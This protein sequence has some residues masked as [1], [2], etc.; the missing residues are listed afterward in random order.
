MKICYLSDIN[1][2]HTQKWCKYFL[3]QGY[4][5]SVISL[6]KGEYPGVKVYDLEL[7]KDVSRKKSILGKFEYIKRVGLVRK[8][9]NEIKPDILH[10]HYASSYGLL[11][12]LA[13]YHPY[14]I[15]IWGSDIL[16]FPKEGLIQRGIIKYNLKNADRIFST[17]KYMKDEANIYTNKHIDI[18]PF[19]IDFNIFN[20]KK[21]RRNDKIIIG[22]VKSL[23]M[24]YGIDY[25]IK[26]FAKLVN[27]YNTYN[28]E[29]RIL[30]EGTELNF[31]KKLVFKLNV[32]NRV[33]FIRT[34]DEYGVSEFYNDIHI[35]AFPSLSEG[36]GVA[37]LEAQ[38]CGIPVVV[39]NIKAFEETTIP[40]ITSL[41]CEKANEQSL[42][43][44]LEKLVLNSKLREEMGKNAV[45]FV[46]D[47]FDINEIFKDVEIIY[48]QIQNKYKLT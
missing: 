11:G 18:T 20:D 27:T 7:S 25:L 48:K 32:E 44:A 43:E 26:A 13:N 28:L 17:S 39:S 35:A 24:V 41:I 5:V 8:I 22:I 9:I 36:F 21:T 6:R 42:F 45:C 30:G 46:N 1:S 15:S 33:K 19:G 34:R 10:S 4:E 29:L 16:I 40:R 2:S 12:S 37:V 31:L 47:N 23:E 38:A 14:I 3:Q